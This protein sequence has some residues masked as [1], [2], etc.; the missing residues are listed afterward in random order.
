MTEL[1][2]KE[3]EVNS[4]RAELQV[5]ATTQCSDGSNRAGGYSRV[6]FGRWVY[7]RMQREREA[8]R[9]IQAERD[10][11]LEEKHRWALVRSA[12]DMSDAL[13]REQAHECRT[14]TNRDVVSCS[15]R[16]SS[17]TRPKSPIL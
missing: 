5:H 2:S 4:L 1:N 9:E 7:Q 14:Y 13:T 16:I 8:W 12:G 6:L 3:L 15:R 11:L 10:A 17:E